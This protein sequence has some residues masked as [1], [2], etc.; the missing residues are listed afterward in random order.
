MGIARQ[1]DGEPVLVPLRTGTL[2]RTPLNGP[3]LPQSGLVDVTVEGKDFSVFMQ[4]LRERAD[5]IGET[6]A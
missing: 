4:D 2:L 3:T 1:R 5:M 6:S